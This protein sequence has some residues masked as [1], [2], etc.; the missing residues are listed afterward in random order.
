MNAKTPQP[1]AQS[2]ATDSVVQE[3]FATKD[4]ETLWHLVDGTAD[5]VGGS[6]SRVPALRNGRPDFKCDPSKIVP[7]T[8]P[9]DFAAARLLCIRVGN[10]EACDAQTECLIYYSE[11]HGENPLIR[12]IAGPSEDRDIA[13]LILYRR[14][15]ARAP[16]TANIPFE[17]LAESP[18][19]EAANDNDPLAGV[20]PMHPAPFT[21]DA[22]GGILADVAR[23]V[24]SSAI[25]PA[26]ELSLAASIALVAGLFGRKA[27]T[28]TS[29][30]V[31][32][33]MTTLLGTAGGKGHPP[34]AIRAISDQCGAAGVVT[35]GDPTSYA[36]I[37]RMLR[38]HPS[39]VVVMD[40]FGL[41]LQ[42]VN[43]K[44]RNAVAAGIRKILLSVYDQANS[45]F[46]GRIYA[47]AETK[48]DEAPI[49]GPALTVLAMTTLE[50]LYAGLSEASVADGFINR[51]VFITASRPD[52]TIK[53]PGL[54]HTSKPPRELVDNV[55][56]AWRAFPASTLLCAA[57]RVV[58]FEGGQGGAAYKL[59]GDIFV[60]QQAAETG[61]AGRAA[62]NT[63]RLATLRAISR[64]AA[65]PSVNV[66]DVKW[67]WAIVFASLD[68]VR[69]GM[70]KHMSAS[71]AEALRKAI[72]AALIEAKDQTLP[73]SHVLQ[74]KGVT[75]ANIR[76]VEGAYQWLIESG[77]I[78]D[79]ASRPKPGPGSRFKLIS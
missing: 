34:K 11:Y 23:W 2:T 60:W 49:V 50:T 48:K 18:H 24:T 35:N 78:A 37:E 65:E 42:D 76:D 43:A 79:I 29:G 25:V 28:P 47:S 57:K 59:W 70:R 4:F 67:G 68:L 10:I 27:L 15:G 39:T 54:D 69:D 56:A 22:A 73:H 77:Q 32:M 26:P 31:N 40:E 53:P 51:F 41:T 8:E 19:P 64:N 17:A 46:D 13:K 63:L 36:A 7:A 66:E 44:S 21:P 3:A 61:T 16:M 12:Q 52:G 9:V 75:G 71:P 1:S 14:L 33:Y 58:P 55:Q 62:E 72:V 6:V 45:V 20:P 30:G 74:R 38:K 5:E